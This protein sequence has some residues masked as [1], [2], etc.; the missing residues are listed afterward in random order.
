MLRVV[1]ESSIWK[2]GGGKEESKSKWNRENYTHANKISFTHCISLHFNVFHINL[3][4]DDVCP[5]FISP[6]H[7]IFVIDKQQFHVVRDK[8]WGFISCDKN[9]RGFGPNY[10]GYAKLLY[11]PVKHNSSYFHKIA[12]RK[13][14]EISI[15]NQ[16]HENLR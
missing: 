12:S 10:L 1:A 15:L 7:L 5:Y 9:G 4:L 6:W 13:F 16:N 2:W 11:N 3:G 14:Q 8:E